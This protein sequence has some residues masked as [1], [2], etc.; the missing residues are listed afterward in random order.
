MIFSY[1]IYKMYLD[2]QSL[3]DTTCQFEMFTV[4]PIHCFSRNKKLNLIVRHCVLMKF[5][6]MEQNLILSVVIANLLQWV[7]HK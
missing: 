1:Q 5:E 4:K 7:K 3:L 2:H 6:M